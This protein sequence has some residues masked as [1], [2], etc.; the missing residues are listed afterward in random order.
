MFSFVVNPPSRKDYESAKSL[1]SNPNPAEAKYLEEE[2][3]AL[4]G[5]GFSTAFAS[6]RMGFYSILK[7][8]GVKEGDEVI[9]TGFTCSVMVNAILRAGAKPIFADIE[10]E[11]LGTSP[12]SVEDAISARTRVVVAQHSFGFPCDIEKIR[13]LCEARGIFLV[14]DCALTLGSRVGKQRVGNFGSAALYST[15]HTKPLNFGIGGFV[16]TR[17]F[18]LYT[19]L[20]KA[21]G[22]ADSLSFDKQKSIYNQGLVESRLISKGRLAELVW[23]N[24]LVLRLQKYL[25]LESPFFDG[26]YSASASESPYPY[27]APIP[28]FVAA[29][30]R[31]QLAKVEQIRLG[32]LNSL[33]VLLS[34]LEHLDL[35]KGPGPDPRTLLRQDFLPNRLVFLHPAGQKVREALRKIIVPEET[36]FLSNIVATSEPAGSYGYREGSC[37]NAEA[38]FSTIVNIPIPSDVASARTLCRKIS[39]LIEVARIH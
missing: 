13:D 10:I 33:E 1:V 29:I 12:Q 21:A 24:R 2:F 7:W 14:E 35:L 20:Q 9:V 38:T 4:V 23:R 36:W 31:A 18:E 17:D 28:S 34:C 32:R 26:D 39:Q 30:G 22:T 37:P 11:T 27:P 15:D 8:K 3:S 16:F 19:Y 6:A 5:P 25:R